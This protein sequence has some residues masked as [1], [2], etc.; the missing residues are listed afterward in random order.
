MYW[1]IPIIIVQSDYFNPLETFYSYAKAD[2]GKE[3]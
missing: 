3:L 2:G 1:E